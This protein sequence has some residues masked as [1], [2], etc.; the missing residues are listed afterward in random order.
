MYLFLLWG[1]LLFYI[2]QAYSTYFCIFY[3]LLLLFHLNSSQSRSSSIRKITP[4]DYQDCHGPLN[5]SFRWIKVLQFLD[6]YVRKP[7]YN[8]KRGISIGC[9]MP[10]LPWIDHC[11]SWRNLNKSLFWVDIC[12][13]EHVNISF[14]VIKTIWK[15]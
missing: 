11:N 7:S 12:I 8:S 10:T 4:L 3:E 14:I 2:K 13:K 5:S 6:F 1:V 9:F 15:T